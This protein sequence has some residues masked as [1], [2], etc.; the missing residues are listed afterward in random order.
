MYYPSDMKWGP[1]G[2]TAAAIDAYVS[3]RPVIMQDWSGHSSVANSK[4]LQLMGVDKFTPLQIV[5]NDPA[6][7]FVRGSGTG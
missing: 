3:D 6:P 1:N 5:A 7:Q 2:P 4:A